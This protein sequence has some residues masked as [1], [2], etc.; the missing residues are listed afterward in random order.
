MSSTNII[1]EHLSLLYVSERLGSNFHELRH[2]Y[3]YVYNAHY[4]ILHQTQT[5]NIQWHSPL[6]QV[7]EYHPQ[8]DQGLRCDL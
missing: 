2:S 4:P 7:Q 6:P 5:M 8:T 3:V 1:K